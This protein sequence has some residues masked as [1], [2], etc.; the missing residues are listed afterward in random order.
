MV[1]LLI[2]VHILVSLLLV[3][4]VLI[5]SGKGA[6]SANIFGGARAAENVFGAST[7]K[8]INGITAALAAAFII[9]STLMTVFVGRAQT[10]VIKRSLSLPA[11]PAQPLPA[12]DQPLE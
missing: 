8:V 5:Q 11:Q 4:A 6:A 3:G 10:S 9:T 2:A 7:P 12:P 1:T